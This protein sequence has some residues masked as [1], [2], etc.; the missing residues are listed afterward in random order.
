MLVRQPG[1]LRARTLH[2]LPAIVQQLDSLQ[3]GHRLGTVQAAVQVVELFDFECPACQASHQGAW[4]VVRKYVDAGVASYTAYDLPLPSHRA[5]VSAAIVATCAER[6]DAPR[7][8]DLRDRIFTRRG[9]WVAAY[10]AENVL[11]GIAA[12]AG[13]DSAAVRS[14]VGRD[15]GDLAARYA[16]AFEAARSRGLTY[17]PVW[18]VNGRPADW[19][20]ID[21]AIQDALENTR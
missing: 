9:E 10:P 12:D 20:R 18:S 11:L 5:A 3:L 13:L 21:Q 6:L 17:I 2:A 16:R 19:T 15:G 1:A 8:W 4:P 14:C 7:A